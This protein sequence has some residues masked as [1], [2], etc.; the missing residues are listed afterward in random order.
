MGAQAKA[1]DSKNYDCRCWG[2]GLCVSHNLFSL[3]CPLQTF[4]GILLPRLCA[5]LDGGCG[6]P[7]K[8]FTENL[9][10]LS[11]DLEQPELLTQEVRSMGFQASGTV[12][13]KIFKQMSLPKFP[14][15]RVGR[16]TVSRMKHR[17][18]CS[19]ESV[20]LNRVDA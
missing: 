5:Q 13:G 20:E 10:F 19:Q 7:Q 18:S 4:S 8:M 9:E 3:A 14:F 12:W 11:G 6:N 17:L 2:T 1:P 16:V 15:N